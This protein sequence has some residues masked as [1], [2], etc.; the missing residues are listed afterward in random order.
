MT[1]PYNGYMGS[2]FRIVDYKSECIDYNYLE[3]FILYH[4][5]GLKDNKTGSAIPHLNKKIFNSLEIYLP[6]LNVQENTAS[7]IKKSITIFNGIIS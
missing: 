5:Q 4:K 3:L 6:P 2:T 7:N 1:V